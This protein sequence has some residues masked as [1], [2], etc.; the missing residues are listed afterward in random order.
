M[1]A[2]LQPGARC[3]ENGRNDADT[4]LVFK[5]ANLFAKP[6]QIRIPDAV[7]L[8]PGLVFACR[9]LPTLRSRRVRH[10]LS[11]S[12]DEFLRQQVRR[13]EYL[14]EFALGRFPQLL[15]LRL[16]LFELDPGFLQL[17]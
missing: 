5:S 11:D 8:E 4:R 10:S 15:L 7:A 6:R 1:D 17:E 9:R 12:A 14:T 13:E 3:I 16:Q 2:F